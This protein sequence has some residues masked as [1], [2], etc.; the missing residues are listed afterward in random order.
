MKV[1]SAS[2]RTDIP[3]FY[4]EWLMNRIRAGYVRWRNARSGIN[5]AV[6]LRPEDVG[7]IVFR[8]KNYVPLLPHLDELD[9][10]GYG[11]L[12][13]LTITGLPRMFEP[14]VPELPELLECARRE[15][16]C[17]GFRKWTSHSSPRNFC[18]TDLVAPVVETDPERN[19]FAKLAV[20]MPRASGSKRSATYERMCTI[21]DTTTK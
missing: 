11:L 18:H 13:H 6:S 3:A 12:F 10:R 4:S 7:A 21:G 16:L 9:G 1:I 8:S 17:R 14:D 15:R 2:R 19:V 5:Y 20:E